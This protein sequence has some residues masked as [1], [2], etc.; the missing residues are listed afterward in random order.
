MKSS[1]LLHRRKYVALWAGAVVVGSLLAT[2]YGLTR[3][4]GETVDR[5]LELA[6]LTAQAL[7]DHLTQSFTVIDR[8]LANVSAE[9]GGGADLGK[10]LRQAP[11]LRSVSVLNPSGRIAASSNPSNVGVALDRAGFMPA[12]SGPL[13]VLRVGQVQNGRDFHDAQ[14]A[15]A[16][17]PQAITNFIPVVRDVRLDDGGLITVAA[18]VNSDYFLNFYANHID[19]G[20]GVVQLL[21]YDGVLLLSTEDA[22]KPGALGVNANVIRRVAG[23]EVGRFEET[24]PDG[25]AVLTAYRA[26][27]VYPYVLVV[28]LDKARAL[29]AWREETRD[30]F[31]IVGA[32]LLLALAT[33]GWS[34]VRYEAVAR[35]RALDRE[36]LR[37]AAIAFESQE[38]MVV[39]NADSVILQVNEAFTRITGYAAD[40]AVGR[41]TN[42]LK[43]GQ[44]DQAFYAAIDASLLQV[45]GYAGEILN[46]HRDGSVHPHYLSI[47]AVRSADGQVS[48][49]VATLTDITERKLAEEALLTLSRAIEQSPVCIVITDAQGNI[50]YVNPIFEKATGYSFG[51]VAGQNPRLLK[52]GDKSADEYRGMWDTLTSGQTWQGEFHNRRKDGSLY[53]ELASISPV[54]N[55]KGVLRHFVAV[56]ENITERKA[57]EARIVELHRDFV[58]FLDNTSDFVY[59]KDRHGRLRIC[60]R[61][62][63]QVAGH[64]DWRELIGKSDQA[65]FPR[66]PAASDAKDEAGFLLEGRPVLNRVNPYQSALGQARWLSTNEWPL[67][68]EIGAVVGRFGIST[69]ITERKR[70]EDRLQLAASVFSHSREGIMIT[71]ADGAII[72]VN[73]AFTRITGYRRQDVLGANPRILNS[74]RQGKE[75]Y[76]A[77]WR[78]LTEKG[79]WYGEVWNRRKSGEV[80]A[81]MQTISAVRDAAG[82]V[83]QYVALFSDITLS[84]A[85]EQQL[86]HLAHYDALTNLPNRVLLADRLRQALVHA[87]RHGRRLAVVYVDLDGFKAV[88]DGYGHEAGDQLLVAIANRMKQALREG[89]TVARIGGDEFAAVLLDLAD[90]AASVPMLTRLL[91]AA[92]SPVHVGG[93]N[94]Q[95]SASIGVTYFPQGEV[96]EA[97]QLLRQADQAMYQAKIAGKNGF[98]VFD[99]LQD[100]N[101][102]GHHE[103]LERVRRG[104]ARS[105]M[106]LHY[107]PKVNLRT[108]VVIGVEGLI[109]WQDPERGLLAPSSFLSVIEDDPLAVEIGEWVITT[110]LDQLAVWRA[111]G[112]DICVSVNVWPRQIQE[113][114]FVGRLRRL[115]LRHPGF[116]PGGL[117]L[118]ILESSALEDLPNVESVIDAS[119][120]LGVRFVLDDFGTGYSSLT[121]LKRLKIG[122][123]KI[124][125][126]FVRN[127]L[128]DPDD[129]AIIDGVIGLASAFRLQVVAEGLET[130]E[131]GELLLKLGCELA[132]GHGIAPPMAAADLLAWMAAWQPH[133]SWKA[134]APVGRGGLALL[135]ASVEHRAWAASV[136]CYVRGDC[137]APPTLH[138]QQCRL[139]LWMEAQARARYGA[140]PIYAELQRLHAEVH[141]LAAVLCQLRVQ[142]RGAVAVGRLAELHVLRNTL[143]HQINALLAVT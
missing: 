31:L 111:A 38:G 41:H 125:R 59:F 84:K 54:Y 77:M 57:N 34:F 64:E 103:S 78:S 121:Y 11:Y 18:A 79:H 115:L 123:L 56:K 112:A 26:S 74:G 37:I 105:E 60:S 6:A 25:A 139:G 91:A 142:G 40:E 44:H 100:R 48:H 72:D 14:A 3:L 20:E 67:F 24:M 29:S 43:S 129:L 109:R 58:A 22:E 7:E 140:H 90:V 98:H 2:G 141:E 107:Q 50:E 130:V 71:S 117:E 127:M 99:A 27:R 17:A 80:Y 73:D 10:A 82:E 62:M 32:V 132:Q 143:I 42:L 137:D 61:A 52:S 76:A 46:K 118:E 126:S 83:Q 128:H 13:E 86:E 136:E 15:D 97:D 124:D 65:V 30:T 119:R 89:D 1:D 133:P 95:V 94:L 66:D 23:S 134:Q 21:R 138:Q 114:G 96:V 51:E 4:R 106:V 69:D 88:N 53:W 113:S 116:K 85:H 135:F 104:F 35:E 93:M 102:R 68:D 122:Q 131:H 9:R 110:A 39:T 5:K 16:L 55:D 33:S 81:E 108:G 70:T 87:Q 75:Y 12:A 120:A 101:V 47:T 8:T 45:G 19:A 36:R 28:R 92:A 63:A 49:F